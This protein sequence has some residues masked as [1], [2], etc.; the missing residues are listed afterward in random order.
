MIFD[1]FKTLPNLMA[2]S[3]LPRHRSSTAVDA[4]LASIEATREWEHRKAEA[5]RKERAARAQRVEAAVNAA[6]G[7][8]KGAD[9]TDI[10][11]AAKV[12][13]ISPAKMIE[14]AKA[15]GTLSFMPNAEESL[16][17][18]ALAQL[19]VNAAAKARRKTG[20]DDD[21]TPGNEDDPNAPLDNPEDDDSERD[22]PYPEEKK[23]NKKKG[24][25][26][27]D[28]DES[29]PDGSAAK[30]KLILSAGRKVQALRNPQP[31]GIA[32]KIVAAAAKARGK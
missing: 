8:P 26:K 32:A 28:D 23:R 18:A 14:V 31:T 25:D 16:S 29:N 4:A 17:P 15:F 30:A 9:L 7:K 13:G 5:E 22:C 12:L 11:N 10:A 6:F 3:P 1:P 24:K 19:V 27:A 21:D 2:D 20:E